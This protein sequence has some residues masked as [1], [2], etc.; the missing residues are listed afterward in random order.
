MKAVLMTVCV[1]LFILSG[2]LSAPSDHEATDN[3]IYLVKRRALDC[4]DVMPLGPDER[5]VVYDYRV[6]DPNSDEPLEYI[7][8][9]TAQA[10]P[11][12]LAEEPE[13]IPQDDGRIRLNL[14]MTPE[15][16]NA[17]E[18][19]TQQNIGRTTAV[20]IGNE[21]VT[22]HKIKTVIKGGAVQVSRCSDNACEQL[23]QKLKAR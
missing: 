3:G 18:A 21:I 8:L 6:I 15:A 12:A 14:Q 4:A 7:V 2:C 20:V 5:L 17:F 1:G 22:M 16:G 23:L 11:L 19:F 9:D 13:P 10:V